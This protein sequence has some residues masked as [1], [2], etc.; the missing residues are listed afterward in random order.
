MMVKYVGITALLVSIFAA[1]ALL[2]S[3]CLPTRAEEPAETRYLA[4]Q[5]FTGA[6]DPTLAIGDS[7]LHPLTPMPS[8]DALNSFVED[9]RHKIGAVGNQS[10]TWP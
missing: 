2:V 10:A 7:G 5:I 4:F 9:I 8:Q 1:V 6:S 3:A